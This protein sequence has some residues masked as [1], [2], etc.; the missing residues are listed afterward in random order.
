MVKIF[1]KDYKE[2][3]QKIKKR[4]LELK[5]GQEQL[6]LLTAPKVDRAKISDIENGKE[7]FHFSTFLRLCK[8]LDI[9][10]IELIK[11]Y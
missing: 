5:L 9:D 11:K 6:A 2:L 10:F 3:G 4:R 1:E 8:A 7:D